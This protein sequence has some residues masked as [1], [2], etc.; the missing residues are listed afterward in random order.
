MIIYI[1]WFVLCFHLVS[2][3]ISETLEIYEWD[4]LGLIH[5]NLNSILTT[6]VCITYLTGYWEHD[7]IIIPSI[8]IAYCIYDLYRTFTDYKMSQ[9]IYKNRMIQSVIVHHLLIIISMYLVNGSYPFETCLAFLSEATNIPLN[10]T[11]YLIKYG[12]DTPN[13]NKILMFNIKVLLIGYIP[14]RLINF[15]YLLYVTIVRG[16]IWLL[17]AM[18]LLLSLNI[19]WFKK[20]YN[21]FKQFE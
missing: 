8:P 1:A 3:F 16:N 18:T 20:I 15:T 21:K 11:W 12:D 19:I 5:S 7:F 6:G 14:L 17:C 4:I 9:K 2:E 10:Y 13:Y